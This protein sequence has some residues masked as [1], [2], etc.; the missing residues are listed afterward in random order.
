MA[1]KFIIAN[2]KGG[3][4][5][6]MLAQFCILH[7]ARTVRPLRA[8]E[9]DRQPKLRRFFG[10]AVLTY[11][12]GPDWQTQFVDGASV[13]AFWDPIVKLLQVERPLVADFGAQVWDYFAAW[14]DSVMLGELVDTS[15][16]RILIPVTADAEAVSGALK[17]VHTSRSIL[18][19]RDASLVVLWSDKDGDPAML[20]GLPEIV[21][22]RREITD[23]GIIER[24]LPLLSR[25]G[26]P[27][28]AS[29]GWHFDRIRKAKP[30]EVVREAGGTAML[31]ARTIK[32]VRDWFDAMSQELDGVLNV[33]SAVPGI[34]AR[35]RTVAVDGT[36]AEVR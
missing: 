8:I 22:L 35:G 12:I 7:V 4:G 15:R 25:E 14:A 18:P 24:R 21:E 28:L 20:E 33:T 9:V 29:R 34:Q 19:A 6:S 31:A 36:L 23:R 5:K 13:A 30:A 16:I 17:I 27:M 11:P 32:S 26:Y 10:E 3:V 1:S 2:D